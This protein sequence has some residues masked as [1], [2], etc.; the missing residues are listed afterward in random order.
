MSQGSGNLDLLLAEGS[1]EKFTHL[2]EDDGNPFNL[3]RRG[4]RLGNGDFGDIGPARLSELVDF[5]TRSA[6]V[7]HVLSGVAL[8]RRNG[9][10]SIAERMKGRHESQ[11]VASSEK[12]SLNGVSLARIAP[13]E[14]ETHSFCR[15][16]W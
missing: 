5:Y 2:G 4:I 7:S 14:H 16:T 1:D 13:T 6:L 9:W 15:R 11:V 3:V 8:K 10:R 12:G